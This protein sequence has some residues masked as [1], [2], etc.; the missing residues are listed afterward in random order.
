MVFQKNEKVHLI[1]HTFTDPAFNLACEEYF[2]KQREGSYIMLWRNSS[3]IIIGINQNA[4][5][6]LDMNFVEE[7]N[8]PVIRRLTGGGAVYH[9]LGNLNFTFITRGHE[10]LAD[11]KEFLAPVTA[12]L[13]SLGLDAEFSG[14]N[15]ILV[16]GMKVSG[17]AQAK[18]K[19]KTMFHG[20]LL[21]SASLAI[22]SRALK[23][24]PL[25]LQAKGISSVVSRVANMQD[26]LKKDMDITEFT[27]GLKRHFEKST[28]A[29]PYH[30]TPEDI[31][32][33]EDLVANKYGKWDWNIGQAPNYSMENT[34]LLPGGMVSINFSVENGLITALKISGDFFGSEPIGILEEKIIGS[35]HNR[36]KL[37]ERL[38]GPDF[39]I[40]NFIAN[41][42][43]EALIEMFFS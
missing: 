19:D 5:A 25:K 37:S 36:Q 14:R 13:R 17:N 10:G 42:K 32:S 35:P 31:K 8:I 23:P 20:T 38:Q 28:Q 12:Y 29:E 15:D 41:T 40:S 27:Q 34:A 39:N 33:I 2:L 11:F 9:D 18:H 21:F 1:A 26:L 30:L 24:N 4:Y 3:S 6:E 16:D 7:N 43:A 22:L